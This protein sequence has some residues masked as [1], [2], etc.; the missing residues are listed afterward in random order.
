MGRNG[1][2]RAVVRKNQ[3]VIAT[4]RWRFCQ[5]RPEG[6]TLHA[7]GRALADSD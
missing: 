6:G 5:S 4:D 3:G 2:F 1:L 7:L